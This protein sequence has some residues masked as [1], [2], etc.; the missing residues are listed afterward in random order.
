M[1]PDSS[2]LFSIPQHTVIGALEVVPLNFPG[3][4]EFK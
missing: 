3:I 1:R 2:P 4:I